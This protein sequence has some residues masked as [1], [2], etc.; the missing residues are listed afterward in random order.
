MELGDGE[1]EEKW[2][3]G[4]ATSSWDGADGN[5][6]DITCDLVMWE[7]IGNPVLLSAAHV[8][9]SLS[10]SGMLEAAIKLLS[11]HCGK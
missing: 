9:R 4:E 10:Q 2:E 3:I 8:Q 6:R 1:S 5:S 7:G 11:E